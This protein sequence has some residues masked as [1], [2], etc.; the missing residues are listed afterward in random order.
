MADDVKA[1]YDELA[2]YYHL[3]FQDWEESIERQARCLNLLLETELGPTSLRIL[4]CACGIGTQSIGFARRGHRV[5]GSDLSAAAVKRVRAEFELKGLPGDF[6]VSDMTSLAEIPDHDFDVVVALDNALPHL[7][8]DELRDAVLAMHGRL[9]AGGLL[10]AGIRD[11]D[12]LIRERPTVQ[13][14]FFF[15][16]ER[17]RRVVLQVWDWLDDARYAIHLYITVQQ[18]EHWDCHHFASTYR[19]LQRDELSLALAS[20]GFENVRWIMPAESGHYIPL[21]LA[22][23]PS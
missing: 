22:R 18:V 2:P 4:D 8:P 3:I 10:V 15:G 13:G 9:R 20:V 16:L 23:K 14:P 11:Y 17:E 6:V 7:S 19:C 5:V 12:A 21:M 1:F